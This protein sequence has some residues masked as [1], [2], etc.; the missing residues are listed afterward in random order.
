MDIDKYLDDI[1][2]KR[3]EDQSIRCPHC[4]KLNYD[5]HNHYSDFELNNLVTYWGEDGPQE[6]Y[7]EHC[8]ALFWV[9]ENVERT[10]DCAKT[11]ND[12]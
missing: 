1:G 10:F 11:E 3:R 6:V 2:K 8:D 9:K 4:N 5:P 12:L 7:C